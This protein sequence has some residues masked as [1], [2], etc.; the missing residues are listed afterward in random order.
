MNLRYRDNSQ[1]H[2]C[3]LNLKPSVITLNP[4][5]FTGNKLENRK[6]MICRLEL[7]DDPYEQIQSKEKVGEG[8]RYLSVCLSVEAS[9]KQRHTRKEKIEKER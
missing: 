9:K 2:E 6:E 3:S 4:R 5:K 7:R 8:R 1:Y